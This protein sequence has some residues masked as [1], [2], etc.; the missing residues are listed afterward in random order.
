MRNIAVKICIS[1]TLCLLFLACAGPIASADS[2]TVYFTIGG[3]GITPAGSPPWGTMTLNLL[4]NGDIGV[5]LSESPSASAQTL[6]MNFLSFNVSGST[7]GLIATGL[8]SGGV[9]GL[10][11]GV[12]GFGG[13]TAG[14][15][16]GPFGTQSPVSFALSRT[17]GFASVN[18]LVGLSTPFPVGTSF[19]VDFAI[20]L[21]GNNASGAGIGGTAGAIVS[22][23]PEPS[24]LL[25]LGSGLLAVMGTCLR[26]KRA[27]S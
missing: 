21:A 10:G 27:E 16:F 4:A 12:A 3:P 23:V 20:G 8:P 6:A 7:S 9:L 13:F 11:S 22:P 15:G 14:V 1:I 26:R 2:L 24:T 5:N 25:L 17:G 19:P 18:N